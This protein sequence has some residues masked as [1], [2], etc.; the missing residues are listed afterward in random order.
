MLTRRQK[1][2]RLLDSSS[3]GERAAAQAAL[4]RL[5]VAPPPPPG[6]PE[7]AAAMI[8]HKRMV[9]ECAVRISDPGLSA[10]DVAAIRRWGRYL[11]R[12]WEDGAE[13]LR[14]IHR[15][16]MKTENEQCP[17]LPSPHA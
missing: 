9:E 8:E 4:D 5:T 6:S 10:P 3:D 13:D 7:W 2:A 16:L 15:Q 1:I 17:L 11:G 14:R 12:P